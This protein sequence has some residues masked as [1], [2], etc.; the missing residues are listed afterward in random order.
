[1]AF[2]ARNCVSKSHFLSSTVASVGQ[3]SGESMPNW[4]ENLAR[5][6]R[7]ELTTFGSGGRRSIQLSYGRFKK[8][9]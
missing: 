8:V 5:P 9:K 7:L 6:A 3:T 4:L 1:M 2:L